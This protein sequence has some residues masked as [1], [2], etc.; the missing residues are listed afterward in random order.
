ML[1]DSTHS[2]TELICHLFK[3]RTSKSGNTASIYRKSC[4]RHL[5]YFCRT[6]FWCHKCKT[7]EFK[8]NVLRRRIWSLKFSIISGHNTHESKTSE[9]FRLRGCALLSSKWS[10]TGVRWSVFRRAQ[11]SVTATN[12]SAVSG[13]IPANI[14]LLWRIMKLGLT[15]PVMSIMVVSWEK[16]RPMLRA[17]NPPSSCDDCPEI[18]GV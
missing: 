13:Q 17:G 10:Y 4:T 15:K 2:K 12:N 3:I 18:R 11:N 5:Q 9:I 8:E 6:G 7:D 14:L 1:L 16:I